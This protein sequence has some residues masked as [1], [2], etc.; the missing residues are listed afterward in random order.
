MKIN[1][2]RRGYPKYLHAIAISVCLFCIESLGNILFAQKPELVI[3]RGHTSVIYA[4]SFSPDGNYVLTTSE[5]N[6]A[7]LWEVSTGR[8]IRTFTEHT[9]SIYSASF[10]PDGKYALTGGKDS[11]AKLWEVSTGKVFRN[12]KG[13]RDM[14]SSVACSPD[15]K[16]VAI[17][18]RHE[19]TM[20]LLEISTG[21]EVHTF[22]GHKDNIT[23][24]AFSPD[25]KYV[26]TGSWDQTAKLW[27]VAT[28]R[29][30]RTFS[31][32]T[33]NVRSVAYSPDG[34]YILTGGGDSTAKL[35]GVSTGKEVRTFTGHTNFLL[36]VAFSPDGKYVMTGSGDRTA[37]LW[38]VST[39]KVIHTFKKHTFIVSSVS[40][41]PNGKYVLTGS[42]DQTVKL[43]EV[44]T[45]NEVRTLGGN[46][47]WIESISCSNDGKYLMTV[48]WEGETD[49]WDLSTDKKVRMPQR[50]SIYFSNNRVSFS[51][52]VKDV[53]AWSSQGPAALWEVSTG[54]ELR[55][56]ERPVTSALYSPDGKYVLIGSANT[57]A[58][59]WEVTSGLKVHTFIGHTGWVTSLSF[60]PDGK[61]IVTGSTD[62]TAKLWEVSTGKEVL[63]FKGHRH[64][65]SS[66]SYSPDGKYVL[67]GSGDST[68]KLWKAKSGEEVRTLAGHASYVL[69]VSFSP[70]G[71]YMLT[72][73]G[74]DIAKLWEVSSGKE[75]R[76]LTGSTSYHGVEC[77]AFSPDGKY[78]LTGT[79]G[80][81]TK[82]WSL[83]TGQLLATLISMDQSDWAVVTPDGR[84]D[85]SQGGMQH[86]YYVQGLE[87]LP[88]ESFFD[89]FYT[90]K[91]LAQVISGEYVTE[92][93]LSTD[94]SKAIKLPPAVKII[95]P[96]TGTSFFSDEIQITLEATDQGG[97]I[98]EIRL[99]QNGKL[100]SE[101]QRGMKKV[102][103]RSEKV[104]RSYH[105]T[106]LPGV[107]M[108][109]ATAFN[110]ERTE[111]M[112]YEIAITL[113]A[114]DAGSNLYIVAIGINEYKNAKYNL[115]YGRPDAMAF[116]QAAEKRAKSIFKRI[117]KYEL[118]DAQATRPAIEAIFKTLASD[119]KPQDAFI[120]YYAGHGV[121]SEGS[122]TIATEFYLIPTDVTK[123]YGDD[124]MLA[125]KAISAARLK[126]FCTTIKAQKQLVVLD[127]CQSG[128][129]VETFAMRGAAEEKAILQLARSA[130]TVVLAATGTEQYATEFKALGHGVFTYALLQGLNG[131]ADGSPLD[132]KVTVKELE[133]YLNDQ[134]P[135]LTKKYR[136]TAQYPN[137]YARGQDF[138]LAISK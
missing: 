84:F 26:L 45:G 53:I 8:E 32:H 102:V 136:G 35:W 105:V 117:V 101:E 29:G 9:N 83:S 111:A 25:G 22:T 74:D 1:Y 47:D 98:D 91:L 100:I 80:G 109:R 60:S 138:P 44:S 37:K 75:V 129:A 36:S 103:S 17:G 76:T 86:M 65:V 97:G 135:E 78:V 28:G 72:R 126:T 116:V 55:T 70:D 87:V 85:A 89:Q 34:N 39:G 4:V 30:L 88:L 46:T 27:E 106:L 58:M 21:T 42:L 122:P 48:S 120:F 24:I 59:L 41:S 69:S 112:P 73:S 51:P 14:V 95:S 131:D 7:I 49:F 31:G 61:Y 12:F 19:T 82:I 15:G 130:G 71:K 114:A 123:L 124:E 107:N 33:A 96:K 11:T 108:F 62:S 6:T 54:K 64:G 93:Q 115:N 104:S 77:A 13:H 110:Q 134:V 56:F 18:Y 67:T 92:K 125:S 118:Y 79:Q 121:M 38:D 81:T 2:L 119:A 137:S 52:D 40:F 3:Q 133:A 66:I 63:T 94:F 50:K 113:Q 10:S 23:S 57:T 5:D 43:W 90:P 128:G 20:K 99:F 127:A 16:Y 68:A 132:G